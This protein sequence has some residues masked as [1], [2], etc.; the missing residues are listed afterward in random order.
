MRIMYYLIKLRAPELVLLFT[1]LMLLNSCRLPPPFAWRI[2]L[3]DDY[4]KP[5]I[6]YSLYKNLILLK[7]EAELLEDEI[8]E[9]ITHL[10][11][12]EFKEKRYNIIKIQEINTLLEDSEFSIHDL[13]DS[14]VLRR[15]RNS[16]NIFAIIRGRV[17][18]Y[19]IETKIWADP[20][21]LPDPRLAEYQVINI[22]DISLTIEMIDTQDWNII[23]SSSISCKEGKITGNTDR[24]VRRMI[25]ECLKKIP[26][27]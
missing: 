7:F 17:N 14:R 8:V 3:D 16:L 2:V 10:T 1:T 26:K 13:W 4:S 5:G 22:C 18:R 11:A 20:M 23:W 19:W 6:D 12:E 25:K 27:H 24:L 21:T 9:K 15:I